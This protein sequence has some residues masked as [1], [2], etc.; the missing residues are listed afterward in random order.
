MLSTG[1]AV[2]S[3]GSMRRIY[4]QLGGCWKD[5]IPCSLLEREPPFPAGC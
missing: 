2:S 5:L 4:A 3:E 1:A